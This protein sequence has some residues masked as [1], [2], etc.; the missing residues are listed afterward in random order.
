MVKQA[1]TTNLLNYI[2]SFCVHFFRCSFK[3]IPPKICFV[4]SE[5]KSRMVFLP[6][7]FL[8]AISCSRCSKGVQYC[9]VIL[10]WLAVVENKMPTFQVIFDNY[11]FT[12]IQML[13]FRKKTCIKN[14][15]VLKHSRWNFSLVKTLGFHSKILNSI[16][17][18]ILF[19]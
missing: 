2:F 19:W 9:S 1:A 14:K 7:N 4:W 6:T 11:N 8:A 5:K 15:L 10:S 16:S 18:V 13:S 3:F 12:S 17:K